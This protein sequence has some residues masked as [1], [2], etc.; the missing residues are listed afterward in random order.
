MAVLYTGYEYESYS[1]KGIQCALVMVSFVRM[2]ML[3][4]IFEELSHLVNILPQVMRD[5]SF[6]MLYYLFFIFT[7]GAF[8]L[9]LTDRDNENPD[10]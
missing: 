2:N 5:L 10:A 9:I 3:L 8:L 7:F 4:S 6:F 1:V